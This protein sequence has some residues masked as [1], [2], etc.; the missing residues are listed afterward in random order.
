MCAHSLAIES[1]S[2]SLLL[3]QEHLTAKC[4]NHNMVK[5]SDSHK[6]LVSVPSF[7]MSRITNGQ[8]IRPQHPKLY[9]Q[10][11]MNI[12]F[13]I[14]YCVHPLGYLWIT[15]PIIDSSAIIDA[16]TSLSLWLTQWSTQP[17]KSTSSSKQDSVVSDL[18]LTLSLHSDSRFL[19]PAH[20]EVSWH[21]SF[22]T[23]CWSWND[24]HLRFD[25]TF[26][27]AVK[28]WEQTKHDMDWG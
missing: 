9:K 12:F 4:I 24:M 14:C 23:S 18:L 28:I 27:S 19:R 2:S 21:D 6:A 15:N 20:D 7:F 11:W 3:K 13:V 8:V 26:L 1:C 17:S 25:E 5:R 10:S 16:Q 22:S